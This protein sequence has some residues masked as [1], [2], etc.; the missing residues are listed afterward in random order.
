MSTKLLISWIKSHFLAKGKMIPKRSSKKWFIK[1]NYQNY[2]NEIIDKTCCLETDNFSEKIYCIINNLSNRPKCKSLVCDNS[3]NFIQYNMGYSSFCSTK[4]STNDKH[5]QEKSSTTCLKRYGVEKPGQSEKIKEK[6]RKTCL[7]RYGVENT[8]QSKEKKEKIKKTCLERYGVENISQK[9]ISKKSIGLLNNKKWLYNEYITRKKKSIQIARELG[10][11]YVF[12]LFKMKQFGIPIEHEYSSSSLEK[13]IISYV[14]LE[15]N[16]KTNIRNIIPPYELDIYIPDYNLA[17]EFDGIFWH[18]SFSCESDILIKNKHL[19]KTEMCVEK[20]IQLLHIFENEWIDPIKQDIWKSIINGKLGR[21]ERIFARKT[22]IR[23]IVD[24]KQV[25]EFLNNN[26]L[27]GFTGSSIKLGLFYNKKLVGLMTFGKTRFSKKY[28]YEMIRFCNKKFTSV[29]GGASKLFKCF[30]RNYKPESV[31]SYADR[32]YSDG[33]L[34][35]KLGFEFSHN[36]APNY[37]YFKH[38]HTFLQSRLKFQKHKLGKLLEHFN[39]NKSEM[40]NMFDNNYRKIWDSGNIIFC[41]N[42]K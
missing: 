11:S 30:I 12:V 29:I 18:S 28:E 24:N 17:I 32:R 21:N 5:V 1:N 23:E 33:N 15:S 31:I 8:F 20:D 34:Y 22:E 40:L 3:V 35:N 26:H 37:W 25:R 36:S 19:I 14:A 2:Y 16:I 4:C 38:G 41:Y 13:E 9:H 39:P 7:E 10:V 42:A 27:Q 6:V